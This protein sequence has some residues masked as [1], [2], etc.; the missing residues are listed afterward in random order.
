[1]LQQD[2]LK[3]RTKLI[4]SGHVLGLVDSIVRAAAGGLGLPHSSKGRPASRN[5]SNNSEVKEVVFPSSRHAVKV[6][7]EGPSRI[8]SA[9]GRLEGSRTLR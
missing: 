6:S 2:F 1:M 7:L 9:P 4:S 3:H 5:R 8:A